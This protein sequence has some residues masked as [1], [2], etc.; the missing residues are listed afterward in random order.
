MVEVVVSFSNG[1]EL[2]CSSFSGAQNIANDEKGTIV[3]D[4]IFKIFKKDAIASCLKM[5]R[6]TLDKRLK[7][8][9]F[10]NE[11]CEILDELFFFLCGLKNKKIL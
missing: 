11:E 9:C 2:I 6:P 7:E 10:N 4:E 8:K 5:S 1:D 3:Y